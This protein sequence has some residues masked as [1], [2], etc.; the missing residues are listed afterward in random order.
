ME[1]WF[2]DIAVIYRSQK[3]KLGPVVYLNLYLAGPV[4]VYH[5]QD[6]VHKKYHNENTTD[7]LDILLLKD[8]NMHTYIAFNEKSIKY[9]YKKFFFFFFVKFEYLYPKLLPE[10]LQSIPHPVDCC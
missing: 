7:K 1:K 10:R 3:M 4:K 9:D 8:Q 2:E 6:I 5:R